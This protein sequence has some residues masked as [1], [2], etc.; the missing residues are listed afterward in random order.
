MG[1]NIFLFSFKQHI[2]TRFANILPGNN[3]SILP[4]Q[5]Y[6]YNGLPPGCCSLHS[7]WSPV[8]GNH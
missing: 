2:Q 3:C 8:L 5:S 1:D 7:I 4:I 6:P